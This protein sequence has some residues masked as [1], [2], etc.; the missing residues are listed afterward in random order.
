MSS[1]RIEP[2]K[3]VRNASWIIVCRIARMIVSFCVSVITTRYLGPSN[4]GLINYASSYVSLFASL[5][6]L[7]INGIIIKELIVHPDEQG[8]IIGTSI[9]L[10]T[11]SS[12][13]SVLAIMCLISITDSKDKLTLGISFLCSLA[14]VFQSVDTVN[15]WFQSRYLSKYVSVAALIGYVLSSIYKIVLFLKNASVLYFAFA[16]SVDYLF[17]AVLMIFCYIKM[18][19]PRLRINLKTGRRI[20]S[21]SYHYI[22]SGMMVAVYGQTDKL[23]LKHMLNETIVGYYSLATSIN[24][25]WVFVLQAIIDSMAPTIVQ[26]YKED[27]ESFDRKN[28]Q[29][30]SIV[31]Y[32]SVFVSFAFL[33]FGKIAIRSIY[34]EEFSPAASILN[35]VTWYTIFSYLGVARNSWIVCNNYQKYLKYM[36]ISAIVINIALNLVLIP[37]LGAYGAALASL[38]TQICTSIIIPAMIPAMRSNVKLIMKGIMLR[39]FFKE[40]VSMGKKA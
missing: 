10:R 23:M 22:L 7:G 1:I 40:K 39:G 32:L 36:Y 25:I 21:S 34:G 2:K 28:T 11:I 6:T 12:M 9:T 30:Y 24:M 14:L 5:C 19:G 26:L 27:K 17:E 18:K 16:T 37:P 29:L 31:I 4:Y 3:E 35:V 20:L 33:L 38:I 8:T 15:Y 13:I